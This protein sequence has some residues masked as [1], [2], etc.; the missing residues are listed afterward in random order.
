MSVRHI[1]WFSCGDASPVAC[2]LLLKEQPGAIIARIIIPDEL[3]DANRFTVDCERWYGRSILRLQDPEKRSTE[4]VF[5]KRRYVQGIKG[6]PCTGELKKAVR[7]AFQEP[8]DVHVMG[9]TADEQHRADDFQRN[10]FELTA[11]FPL[12]RAGLTKDDCH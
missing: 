8:D 12:I 6:A 2:A 3:P 11:D 1:G 5:R 10:N 9:F 7:F 4:D